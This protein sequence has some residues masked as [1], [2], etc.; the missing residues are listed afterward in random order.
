MFFVQKS[1][2]YDF[3]LYICSRMYNYPPKTYEKNDVI[4]GGSGKIT[5]K[6]VVKGKGT[7][8]DLVP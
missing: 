7:I 8:F 6:G 1:V 5:T 2:L 4:D 3:I